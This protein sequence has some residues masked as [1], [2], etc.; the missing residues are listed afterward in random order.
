ML[1][2]AVVGEQEGVAFNAGSRD[3]R[4]S[5]SAEG[6]S[7]LTS[8]RYFR[9]LFSSDID[10]FRPSQCSGEEAIMSHVSIPILCDNIVLIDLQDPS[11]PAIVSLLAGGFAG[12]VEGA[13]TVRLECH[14]AMRYAL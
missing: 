8:P 6:T 4:R 11:T 1:C 9:H 5:R 13:A 7:L 3:V 2:I 12:A 14:K 10:H